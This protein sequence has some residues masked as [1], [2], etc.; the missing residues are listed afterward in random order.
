MIQVYIVY[1][2]SCQKSVFNNLDHNVYPCNFFKGKTVNRY[3][4]PQ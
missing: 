3:Y 1:F 2:V 4:N